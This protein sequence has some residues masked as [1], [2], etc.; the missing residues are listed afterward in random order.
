MNPFDHFT[1][2]EAICKHLD[3]KTLKNILF[4]S[5]KFAQFFKRCQWIQN[6]ILCIRIHN[7][8]RTIL[9]FETCDYRM[10]DVKEIRD[11]IGLYL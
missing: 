3:F 1:I 7:R 2:I 8:D 9:Y 11:N 6:A 5:K 4:V 10:V